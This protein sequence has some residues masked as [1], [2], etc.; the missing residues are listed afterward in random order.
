MQEIRG[1]KT[2]ILMDR[3]MK[4][5]EPETGARKQKQMKEKLQLKS[6]K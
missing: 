5:A 1:K 4:E 3:R 6:N 2:Q